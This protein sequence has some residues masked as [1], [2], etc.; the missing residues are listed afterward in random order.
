MNEIPIM[1]EAIVKGLREGFGDAVKTIE[2]HGG[3]YDE[4]ETRRFT[5][6]APA[7][8]L[9]LLDII[10]YEE[11]STVAVAEL[12]WS[13]HI[14]T[15]DN[16]TVRRREK[17]HALLSR[18]IGVIMNNRWDIDEARRPDTIRA[19]N[20]Y[21]ADTDEM[22]VALW[23]LTWQQKLEIPDEDAALSLDEFNTLF[24][25][26]DLRPAT[27]TIIEADDTVVIP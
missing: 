20:L 4:K 6:G 21:N 9:T 16:N 19:N 12:R 22:G 26:Y 2:Q 25:E 18:A 14:L 27:N 13:L 15:K 24:A 8:L 5:R 23:M 17:A 11:E 10:G 1:G 3:E 7:M